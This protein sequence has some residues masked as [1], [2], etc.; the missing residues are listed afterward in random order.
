MNKLFY[1]AILFAPVACIVSC[2]EPHEEVED[3]MEGLAE[4]IKDNEDESFVDLIEA[5]HDFTQDETPGLVDTLSELSEAERKIVVEKVI[6]SDALKLLVK[7]LLQAAVA[8]AIDNPEM[9]RTVVDSCCNHRNEK[10]LVESVSGLLPYET[11]MQL[12]DIAGD[13]V[14]L[15][16]AAG[17]DESSVQSEAGAAILSV[18]ASYVPVKEMLSPSDYMEDTYVP[19]E[20]DYHYRSME[21]D[22]ETY[23]WNR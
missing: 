5:V 9:I 14:K 1:P 13:I 19:R 3:Y 16:V 20:E 8:Q 21:E 10:K 7:R 2:S 6:K 15:S 18:V 22:D 17:L 11:Q 12:I 4:V 23:N